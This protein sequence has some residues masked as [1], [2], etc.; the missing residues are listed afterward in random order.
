M[1]RSS[2]PA[3]SVADTL[4]N[5]TT[6][7]TWSFQIALPAMTG[8]NILYIP[9]SSGFVLVSTN[10]DYFTYSY[11]GSFPGLTIGEVLVNT[12]LN[13]GYT[14]TVVAFTNYPVSSTVVVLTRPATLAEMLQ[15][16]SISSANFTHR[17]IHL[18][19]TNPTGSMI[20]WMRIIRRTCWKWNSGLE[21]KTLAANI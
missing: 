9:G 10:G 11:T 2:S 1:A 6:N 20:A 21:L 19:T 12:N 14:R 16:G 5:V 18:A 3:I 13:T 7:F 4:G 15:L 8:T 17:A